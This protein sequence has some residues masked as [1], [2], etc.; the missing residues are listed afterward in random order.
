MEKKKKIKNKKKEDKVFY[1]TTIIVDKDEFKRFSKFYSNKLKSSLIPRLIL[2][3]LL[4]LSIFLNYIKG[5][6]VVVYSLIGLGVLYPIALT[7]TLNMQINYM[8]KNN[9]RFHL[10]EEKLS[11]FD[12]YFESKSSINW[13]LV[14][15]E[16]I[17][18][19]CETKS[20][21]YIFLNH[22]QAFII[23]KDK[24]SDVDGFRS[25]IRDKAFYERY[26]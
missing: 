10:T 18:K 1:E 22:N 13:C 19:I 9:K 25:F 23:I 6:F 12:K 8:F 14:N 3:A 16:D 5:N 4:L 2:I 7:V 26:K 17:Y 24:L 20:N 15:Y 11:F 21:F